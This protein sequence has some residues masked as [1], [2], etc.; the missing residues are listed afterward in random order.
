M[1]DLNFAPTTTRAEACAALARA[2]GE[3]GLDAPE[4]EAALLLTRAGGWRPVDMISAP[5]APLGESAQ[6]LAAAAA[7]RLA[8]EPLSRI[9]GTR[10]FW[11]LE[12]AISPD[13]LDPRADTETLVEA[14]RTS[15]RVRRDETLRIL[16]FGTGSGALLCA[17][18]GEFP[19]AT[20]IGVDLS[21]A[22]AEIARA[23]V[24]ALGLGARATIRIGDWGQGLDGPFDLIVSN[25]PYI[26][27]AD[28]AGLDREVREHDPRLALDGGAD[29]LDAY[30]ALA[31]ELT[32]LLEP[33][34]GR[35]FLEFGLGQ[36]EAVRAILE[37][38]GLIVDATLNDLGGHIRAISGRSA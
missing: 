18:L 26:P 21:P 11:S 6:R 13:V 22:A 2:F 35:F 29:G 19:R 8:G 5:D 15:M 31:P 12:F 14:A 16:D 1:V 33:K 28:I 4:R 32:R 10:E 37:R 36:A 38:G 27:A 9:L 17:L 23:N 20:G 7:R 25:P 3:A 24:A 30:R 34:H